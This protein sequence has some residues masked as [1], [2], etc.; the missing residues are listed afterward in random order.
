MRKWDLASIDKTTF[1]APVRHSGELEEWP[2]SV[3]KAIRELATGRQVDDD[4]KLQELLEK[5]RRTYRYRIQDPNADHSPG[6]QV[7]DV[8]AVMRGLKEERRKRTE[9]VGKSKRKAVGSDD[10]KEG[11]TASPSTIL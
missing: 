4:N 5:L 10:D 9:A 6:L 1:P 8:D 2:I 3:L 7:A 11:M